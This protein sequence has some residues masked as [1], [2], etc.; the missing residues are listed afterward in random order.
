MFG[1]FKMAQFSLT[2]DFRDVEVK[3][4]F[5]PNITLVCLQLER[6]LYAPVCTSAKLLT[7][8]KT[9]VDLNEEFTVTLKL[10]KD[11]NGQYQPDEG[12]L[13]LKGYSKEKEKD[14][15][16]GAV[17][18]PFHHFAAARSTQH[19]ALKLV[20]SKG[21]DVATARTIVSIKPLRDKPVVDTARSP[22]GVGGGVSGARGKSSSP[23]K[24]RVG[25]P[26][27]SR[28]VS[29]SPS[30]AV[31]ALSNINISTVYNP[32]P[33]LYTTDSINETDRFRL[34]I[35][36]KLSPRRFASPSQT[37]EPFEQQSR[38]STPKDF[39]AVYD[40]TSHG[41]GG[42]LS[43]NPAT[44]TASSSSSSSA[45]AAAAGVDWKQRAA[46]LESDN[47]RLQAIIDALAGDDIPAASAGTPP[48]SAPSAPSTGAM[49]S[50]APASAA[51]VTPAPAPARPHTTRS[52]TGEVLARVGSLKVRL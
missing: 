33:N 22:G 49:A 44:A 52:P 8:E 32:Q 15:V 48:P 17:Q 35:L 40:G 43:P 37:F 50:P 41:R 9:A 31:A 47:S 29:K 25:P 38:S 3:E 7:R 45:A 6:K 5:C 14:V 36:G 27:P 42:R 21:R 46:A 20:D 12:R 10:T 51:S 24:G 18:L 26:S 30:K 34:Q 2:L 11:A 23:P 4:R 19:L 39:S 28:A 1:Y 16:L 13:V